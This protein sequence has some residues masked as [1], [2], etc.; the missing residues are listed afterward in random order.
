MCGEV[1]FLVYCGDIV[2]G[3][4]FIEGLCMV[5]FGCLFQG[6]YI[7]VLMLN[8]ICVF[9][10]GGFVD[11][12]EVYLWNKGFVQNLVNQWYECMVVEI[13][14]VIKFM[15]VVGVDFDEF[16]CVEFFIGYEG[17]FMDYECLM[18]WIDL[19]MDILYNILVYFLWIGECM[20]EFD[21]VYVDYFFK[22]CNLIGV[23]F[24]LMILLEIVFVLIDKLDL[25]CEF[26]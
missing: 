18:M 1:I 8:L 15:E 5:D 16:K 17:L 23:K 9:I 20:C 14:C 10:Q 6:Y 13:D 25:D 12:C 3:Y 19:W 24:G 7:V 21:G 2:N 11:F 22:I 26:G 4:D